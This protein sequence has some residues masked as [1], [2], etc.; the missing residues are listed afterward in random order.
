MCGPDLIAQEEDS[1]MR[2]D[3]DHPELVLAVVKL[4]SCLLQS[5]PDEDGSAMDV[6][7]DSSSSF[8]VASPSPS[9]REATLGEYKASAK[10]PSDSAFARLPAS[11]VPQGPRSWEHFHKLAK[12][13]RPHDEMF[14][15]SAYDYET[16][17]IDFASYEIVVKS[18]AN[19]WRCRCAEFHVSNAC[20]HVVS[21][22][23]LE[24]TMKPLG[25]QEQDVTACNT[26]STLWAVLGGQGSYR[27]LVMLRDN[28]V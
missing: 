25:T 16:K 28:K 10:K 5:V 14:V 7:D 24:A 18:A 9:P 23:V 6:K 3:D 4:L 20:F 22:A 17:K 11:T 27:S 8:S 1:A 19:K 2:T 13:Y 26:P 12:I 21:A 15:I